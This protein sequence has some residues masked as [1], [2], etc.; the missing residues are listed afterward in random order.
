MKVAVIGTGIA[1]VTVAKRLAALA[2]VNVEIFDKSRGTGGRMSVRHAGEHS[3]DHG[4]QFFTARTRTFKDFLADYRAAGV[5]VEW[6][7]KIAT[8]SPAAKLDHRIWREPHFVALP[9][10]NGLCKVISRDLDVRLDT[11]VHSIEKNDG[12]WWVKTVKET[13]GPYDWVVSTA[14]PEQTRQLFP[15]NIGHGMDAVRFAPC[16]SLLLGCFGSLPAW[17]AAVVKDSPIN[18]LAFSDRKP[19]RNSQPALVAHADG[20][21]SQLQYDTDRDQVKK[22]LIDAVASVVDIQHD[23]AGL[24]RWRYARVTEPLG[25]DFWINETSQL[26]ACGDWCLGNRVED[27]FTSATRLA[28]RFERI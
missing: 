25:Q 21:W 11:Q 27:A 6:Q 26:A 2:H 28:Q 8:L 12:G 15:D 5:V 7:P 3:F 20:A 18:W 13:F 22:L 17:D 14:P 1:G 10:M 16:F 9:D 24:H 19:G 4:A 23:S